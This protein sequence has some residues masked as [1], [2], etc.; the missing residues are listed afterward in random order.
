MARIR[1][2]EAYAGIGYTFNFAFPVLVDDNEPDRN[3]FGVRN[4]EGYYMDTGFCEQ[5]GGSQAEIRA[6]GIDASGFPMTS[7]MKDVNISYRCGPRR[8]D[9]GTT[10]YSEEAPG[11]YALVT[12]LPPGCANPIISASKEGYIAFE[13]QMTEN[14]LEID[15]IKLRK[16]PVAV[17]K[18]TYSE[19]AEE[20][21]PGTERPL[22][23]GDLLSVY[24]RLRDIPEPY[25]Q[26]AMISYD[27]NESQQIEILEQ[28]AQ[29]DIDVM[30]QNYDTLVGGYKAQNLTISYSDLRNANELV[31]HVF[32]YQPRPTQDN[33][34]RNLKMLTYLMDKEYEEELKPTFR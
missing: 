19:S 17:V 3:E 25:D 24:I 12:S 1:D 4:F 22:K 10:G 34:E 33:E 26:F 30:L 7:G 6:I 29:Y 11:R 13:K 27:D 28:D 2:P 8:C 5:A 9:L 14:Y 15:M 20:I 31:L 18:H 16:L 32:E 23:K 21:M